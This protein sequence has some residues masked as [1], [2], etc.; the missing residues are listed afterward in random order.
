M[1]E[2]VS[3]LNTLR[4]SQNYSNQLLPDELLSNDKLPLGFIAASML[5]NIKADCVLRTS[6]FKL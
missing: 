1:S 3:A 4:D 2:H 5:D 6:P